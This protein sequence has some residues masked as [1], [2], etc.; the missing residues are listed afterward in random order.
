M[1]TCAHGHRSTEQ[2]KNGRPPA[3]SQR[4]LCGACRRTDT[5]EPRPQ[6][7]GD[8]FRRRAV[9]FY[10]EGMNLRRIGRP[11]G[12]VHQP[13]ANWV[14]AQAAALPA[15]PPQPAGPVEVADRDALYPCG[16][17]KT[18]SRTL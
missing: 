10:G 2:V 11:R 1:S 8:D 15:P 17:Q 13:V 12:V 16:G 7:S 14:A 9:Q 3:G 6:G 5:P 18:T 4:S